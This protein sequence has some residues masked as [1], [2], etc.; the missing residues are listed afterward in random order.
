[1]IKSATKTEGNKTLEAYI[2]ASE[3]IIKTQL[4]VFIK[5]N[6]IFSSQP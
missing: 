6:L 4:E 3:L 2:N 5:K 1:M